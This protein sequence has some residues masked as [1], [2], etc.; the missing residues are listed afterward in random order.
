VGAFLFSNL[1][2]YLQ[3]SSERRLRSIE[4]KLRVSSE[5]VARRLNKSCSS[6][7]QKLRVD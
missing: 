7:E 1:F 2:V 5:K 4:Q 6:I 3:H